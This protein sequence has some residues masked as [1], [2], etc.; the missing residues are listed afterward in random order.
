[1]FSYHIRHASSRFLLIGVLVLAV[2]ILL[3]GTTLAT[4]PKHKSFESPEAA[5]ES[6]V[7]AL[8]DNDEKSLLDL[9]GP[10]G[11]S[12]VMS[13]DAVD[14]RERREKFVRLYEE[15]NRLERAGD[16]KVV[17]HV[18]NSDW[19]FA[20]PI[21]K[22]A[23]GW[24]FDTKQGKEEIINRRIGENELGAIQTCLAIVDAQRDYASID[25]DGDDLLEYAQKFESTQ[26]KK[27][28][29]YWQV[30]PGEALSP[31]GPLVAQAQSEGYRK[32]KNPTPYNGYYF[33]ILT[34]QGKSAKGGAYSYIVNR[35]MI[36]GFAV[37]AYPAVYASSGVKT[38]IVNHE[39]IVY[40]KDLGPGTTKLAKKIKVF[41]PDD[42]W[43][44]AE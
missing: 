27:D 41:N 17:L 33:R 13:G 10:G 28:G 37:V 35:K 25:R 14:D 4:K 44:K 5:A 12:L 34:A 21:V 29:L 40:E 24:R 15:K 38:F 26:G 8:R 43:E 7:K 32:G 39:G 23:E 20:I 31:L 42:T 2:F 30:A 6:L 3:Q 11:K 19:P 9:F 18:G 16:K 36:G 22:T 1:M